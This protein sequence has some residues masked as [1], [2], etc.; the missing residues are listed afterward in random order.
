MGEDG[1]RQGGGEVGAKVRAGGGE[2]GEVAVKSRVSREGEDVNVNVMIWVCEGSGEVPVGTAV[3]GEVDEQERL[4]R[5]VS[6]RGKR[7]GRQDVAKSTD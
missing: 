7:R 1:G 4:E 6:Q 5:F 3:R 2:E